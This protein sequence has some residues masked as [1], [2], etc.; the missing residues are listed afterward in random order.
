MK[1]LHCHD[2]RVVWSAD[3]RWGMMTCGPCPKCNAEGQAVD[4]DYR[5]LKKKWGIPLT[6]EEK[7]C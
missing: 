6:E 1:C 2:E 3:P 5:E 7:V 4:K